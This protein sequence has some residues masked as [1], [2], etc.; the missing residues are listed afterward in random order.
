MPKPRK[1]GNPKES[2]R[3]RKDSGMGHLKVT[4]KGYLMRYAPEHQ[5]ATG[6]RG[7]VFEHRRVMENHIGRPLSKAEAVHHIN[8]DK[9]DNGIENLEL[10]TMDA[11]SERHGRV[12]GLT[13]RIAD[14]T[15]KECSSCHG[16]LPVTSE[17]Y[18]MRKNGKGT[19]TGSCKLCWNKKTSMKT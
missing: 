11:H 19:A 6:S 18:H 4:S 13:F 15:Y 14:T 2:G 12:H 3:P 1:D 17:H 5:F 8:G 16:T 10:L 7:Y 9:A